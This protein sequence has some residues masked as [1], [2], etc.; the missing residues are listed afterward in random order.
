MFASLQVCNI[1]IGLCKHAIFQNTFY[2]YFLIGFY[3]EIIEQI[4]AAHCA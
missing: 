1:Y 3:I 4:V 2:A